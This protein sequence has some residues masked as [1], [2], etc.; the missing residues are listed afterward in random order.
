MCGGWFRSALACC[1]I[2][3]AALAAAGA[4]VD[5][6]ALELGLANSRALYLVVDPDQAR[7]S[8]R[9]RGVEVD[10][11]QAEAVW[12]AFSD[13]AG[14]GSTAP[15]L[16]AVW[17]VTV[18]PSEGWRRVIAPAELV[19]YD[20]DA[21][22]DLAPT[23]A[24]ADHRPTCYVVETDTGWRLALGGPLRELVPIGLGA[25]LQRG[26]RRLVGDPLPP[27]PPTLVLEM[28]PADAQRVVHLFEV[29]TSIL[30]ARG[31]PPAASWVV[32]R[33]AAGVDGATGAPE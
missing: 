32:A 24:P 28:A 11:V 3:L 16:P 4:P 33:Q 1:C 23:P 17:R 8:I 5:S 9:I 27:L 12:I 2:S 20:E 13:T 14:D 30:V 21:A 26:W 6:A 22:G 7:L 19:A 31:A 10:A 18:A 29:A 25:R 15:E